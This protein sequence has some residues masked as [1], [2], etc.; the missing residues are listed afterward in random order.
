M[1]PSARV[2]VTADGV[3]G[4]AKSVG[5]SPRRQA[6]A[7]VASPASWLDMGEIGSERKWQDCEVV[8]PDLRSMNRPRATFCSSER[9]ELGSFD[10]A[11]RRSTSSM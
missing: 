4:H 9:L 3:N 6:F 1:G 10:A 11:E 5:F 7:G 8:I 2:N